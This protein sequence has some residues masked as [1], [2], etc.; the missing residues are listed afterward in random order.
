MGHIN[1]AQEIIDRKGITERVTLNGMTLMNWEIFK[2]PLDKGFI[3][4]LGTSR[5]LSSADRP[6]NFF[7]GEF[8]LTEPADTYLDLS[9]YKKGVVWVNG[10]N[11]GRFWDIGPQYRLYCPACWLNKGRNEVLVFDLHQTQA[12]PVKGEKTP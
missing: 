10:H 11:L 1:F 7:N 4:S 2:L 3:T 12:M 9:Q 6:G 8:V 5:G